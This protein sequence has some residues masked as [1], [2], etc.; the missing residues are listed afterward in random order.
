VIN[1]FLFPWKEAFEEKI[2][3]ECNSLLDGILLAGLRK[4]FLPFL[5]R[6]WRCNDDHPF[7][8]LRERRT[9]LRKGGWIFKEGSVMPF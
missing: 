9:F 7:P 6:S 1:A 4:G 8:L 3:E 5:D 2:A